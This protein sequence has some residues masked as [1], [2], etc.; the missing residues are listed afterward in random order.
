MKDERRTFNGDEEFHTHILCP[1]KEHID[2][3]DSISLAY[4]QRDRLYI[5]YGALRKV[6]FPI[7]VYRENQKTVFEAAL[8]IGRVENIPYNQTQA[9]L[10]FERIGKYL[11]NDVDKDRYLKPR[12]RLTET[13]L[14]QKHAL[15]VLK[16]AKKYKFI[17]GEE[18]VIEDYSRFVRKILRIHQNIQLIIQGKKEAMPEYLEPATDYI[19]K[20]IRKCGR[21]F[22]RKSKNHLTFDFGKYSIYILVD[23]YIEIL[24]HLSD[25]IKTQSVNKVLDILNEENML[26]SEGSCY[27]MFPLI[28]CVVINRVVGRT[29]DVLCNIHYGYILEK[30][31]IE[32]KKLI[33]TLEPYFQ[34]E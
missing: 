16:S 23:D 3:E 33:G 22:T 29:E 4:I 6:M 17:P 25:N 1:L 31:I 8:L 32:T 21:N 28:N 15:Y 26:S 27:Y 12:I 20:Q 14:E 11:E 19:S 7:R 30:M 5:T 9:G 24:S 2:C 34:T 13:V 10:L 18:E